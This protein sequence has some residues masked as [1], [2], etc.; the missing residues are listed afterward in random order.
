MGAQLTPPPSTLPGRDAYSCALAGTSECRGSR[1]HCFGPGD[2]CRES[3]RC[4][5]SRSKLPFPWTRMLTWRGASSQREYAGHPVVG[6]FGLPLVI[7]PGL[8]LN[9]TRPRFIRRL[10]QFKPDVSGEEARSEGC[11]ADSRSPSLA[12]THRSFTS[13]IQSGLGLKCCPSCKSGCQTCP[14]SRRTTPTCLHT[15]PSLACLGSS[16]RCGSE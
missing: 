5:R 13:S 12:R 2:R 11:S 10:H 4:R 16:L 3:P 15:L 14:A 6:T 9:F 7:Y 1:C 8:K